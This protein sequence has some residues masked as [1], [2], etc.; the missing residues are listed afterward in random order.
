MTIALVRSNR[1]LGCVSL[2]VELPDRTVGP[3]NV[4][5]SILKKSGKRSPR[6]HLEFKYTKTE[7]TFIK[8]WGGPKHHRNPTRLR[9][10]TQ[11]QTTRCGQKMVREKQLGNGPTSCAEFEEHTWGKKLH[12]ANQRRR[13]V[14]FTSTANPERVTVYC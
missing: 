5:R 4:R 6:A 11:I 7:E 8:L 9:L 14:A 12:S 3:M 13:Q 1:T 2:D 10:R